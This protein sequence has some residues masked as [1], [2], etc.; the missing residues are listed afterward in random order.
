M[1]RADRD[2]FEAIGLDRSGAYAMN[3]FPSRFGTAVGFFSML[4][5]CS[6]VALHAQDQS[7]SLYKSKCAVCHG[8]TGKGDT[9]AGKSI[10]ATDLTKSA[11]TKS[12]ADLKATIENGRN[13]MPAYGKS[14]KSGEI[15]GLLA[16]IKTLK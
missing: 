3:F 2:S 1:I 6:G 9:P 5:L 15:T 13:K 7:A 4:S 11:T 12:E 16:Y 10:G 14:L 8:A